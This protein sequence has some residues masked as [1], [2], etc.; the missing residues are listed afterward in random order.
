M[1]L[2]SFGKSCQ[3]RRSAPGQMASFSVRQQAS[4]CAHSEVGMR[5]AIFYLPIVFSL[6]WAGASQAQTRSDIAAGR[7]IAEKICGGCHAVGPQGQ[8]PHKDAPPF[9]EIA[10]RGNVENLEEALG[11]GIVVGHPD[12]PQF[13]FK[14]Q[15][16]GALIAYLKSLSGKG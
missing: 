10:A 9:R 4:K 8:S 6:C 2:K 3:P 7:Q 15:D 1:K 16:V 12:M 13:K 14:A 5:T 11:E